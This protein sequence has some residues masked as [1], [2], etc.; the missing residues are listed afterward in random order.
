MATISAEIKCPQAMRTLRT[1][2]YF[3]TDLPA[4]VGN[5]VKGVI[6]L[7]HG[8][9]NDPSDWFMMSAATRY[10]ADNG[11]ILVAP[12]ADNSF[13]LDGAAG[14]PFYTT[15]TE[16][17]PAQLQRIFKIPADRD[18]NFI[19]GLSM[20][21][22][23]ALHTGLL[24]P[25]RYAAIGSFS[26]VLDIVRMQKGAQQLPL[27]QPLFTSLFGFEQTVPPEADLFALLRRVAALPAHA[28]PALFCSCGLQDNDVSRVLE[29]NL[30]FKA[31]AD[32]LPLRCF[33]FNTWPGVHEWNFW[34]RSLA[35]FIGFIQN[36]DYGERKRQDWA[37]SHQP[38][39]EDGA[40]T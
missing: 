7:L 37:A 12:Q 4:T 11:Y 27:M 20:G 32:A 23:G 21:G 38:P 2:L 13:Y 1:L 3:P 28:Q 35:E 26:G 40:A 34:D 19:A 39:P 14:A 17:L 10:A 36:S 22:Y 8:L 24:H 29:Q 6:T 5:E 33:S 30:A 15:L 9:G 18:K 16:E 25:E 31:V